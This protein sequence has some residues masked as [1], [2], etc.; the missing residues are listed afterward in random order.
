MEREQSRNSV[1]VNLNAE[2]RKHQAQKF[3]ETNGRCKKKQK[4]K[5]S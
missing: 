4:A 3:T 1:P 5:H 2:P